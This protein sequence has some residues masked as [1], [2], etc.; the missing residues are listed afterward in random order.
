MAASGG[1]QHVGAESTPSPG[2][3]QIE[4]WYYDYA[5]NIEAVN[6][7][8]A[9]T[10]IGAVPDWNSQRA[11]RFMPLGENRMRRKVLKLPARVLDS[12][13]GEFRDRYLLHHY[14][15]IFVDGD[16]H[17]S[18][19]YTEEVVTGVGNLRAISPAASSDHPSATDSGSGSASVYIGNKLLAETE[20][21]PKKRRTRSKKNRKN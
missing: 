4:K 14:F 9:C 11:T 5:A 13:T 16:S 20:P 2:H 1:N 21:P 17:Y 18:P 15:E 10:P 3:Y 6:I 19:L 8:Y 12:T 7:H